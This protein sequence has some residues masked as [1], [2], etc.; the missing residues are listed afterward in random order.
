MNEKIHAS[1]R[2]LE[3]KTQQDLAISCKKEK[4]AEPTDEKDTFIGDYSAESQNGQQIDKSKFPYNCHQPISSI[5]G[6]HWRELPRP[7]YGIEI[8]LSNQQKMQSCCKGV[9]FDRCNEMKTAIL[10]NSYE[11]LPYSTSPQNFETKRNTHFIKDLVVERIQHAQGMEDKHKY[12]RAILNSNQQ[13]ALGHLLKV[14]LHNPEEKY[15]KI[16]ENLDVDRDPV[17]IEEK[18]SATN[19]AQKESRAILAVRNSNFTAL[20]E[21]L[22]EMGLDID[23]RDNHGNTLFIIASQQ[24]NKKL[25]KFLLRRG[26]HINAQNHAGNTVLHYLRQYGFHS[27]AD[28]LM[29]K[30]ADD[31][32]LNSDG[33]TCYEGLN[34]QSLELL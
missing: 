7:M 8:F 19:M 20:T 31:T 27:L 24:G 17:G 11:C 12:N 2:I 32:Y 9:L 5:K 29:R 16:E 3:E 15:K 1:A 14:P 26:A 22:D 33:L 6:Y 28:Y 4:K 23:T 10:V 34:K 30:G 18:D 13:D 21:L 25:C